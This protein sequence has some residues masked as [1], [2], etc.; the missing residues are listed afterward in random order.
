VRRM[1]RLVVLVAA[2]GLVTA[3]PAYATN[4]QPTKELPIAGLMLG[5][6]ASFIPA[7][8]NVGIDTSTFDGR[9]S[10]PSTWVI[11]FAGTG[12]VSHLGPMT[13]EG[14]QCTQYHPATGQGTYSDGDFTL[15]ADNGDSLTFTHFGSFQIINNVSH[16]T[17]TAVITGGTGRFVGA[18]GTMT[19][20]GT[21]D[22][23]TDVLSVNYS[24][25]I[26]YNASMRSRS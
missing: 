18:T 21:Q 15:I 1:I 25:A 4:G 6:T 8:P 17:G 14:T 19:E 22:L 5:H 7:G 3:A 11:G 9:C 12:T 24:G 2:L 23:T 10:V 26:T 16:I 13:Y 20:S